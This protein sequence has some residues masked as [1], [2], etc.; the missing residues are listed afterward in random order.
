MKTYCT[1]TK[2]LQVTVKIL[3]HNYNL[4]TELNYIFTRNYENERNSSDRI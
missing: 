3:F 4:L 1:H 2:N